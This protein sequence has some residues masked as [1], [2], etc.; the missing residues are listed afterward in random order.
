MSLTTGVPRSGEAPAGDVHSAT[1]S[2][3]AVI[4]G[5][6]VSAIVTVAEQV[7]TL[8]LPS[9]AVNVT[10]VLPTGKTGGASF[11]TPTAVSQSSVAVDPARKAAITGSVCG[12]PPCAEHSIVTSAGQVMTGGVASRRNDVRRVCHPASLVVP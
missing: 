9:S 4:V 8:P 2:A 5:G 11:V 12:F 10:S 6:C 7:A 1:T 3:G